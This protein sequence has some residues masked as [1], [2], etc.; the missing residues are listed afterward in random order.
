MPART[1]SRRQIIGFAAAACGTMGLTG[2]GMATSLV[3]TNHVPSA[4]IIAGIS[5]R[6]WTDAIQ[7]AWEGSRPDFRLAFRPR[8]TCGQDADL[9]VMREADVL[10]IDSLSGTGLTVT[11][12]GPTGQKTSPFQNLSEALGP[13]LRTANFNAKALLPGAV[14]AFADFKG[15]LAAFPLMLGEVQCYINQTAL[16]DM[17]LPTALPWTIERMETAVIVARQ[18][19]ATSHSPLVVGCGWSDVNMWSAWVKALGGSVTWRVGG[20]DLR[21]S[22]EATRRLVSFAQVARWDPFPTFRSGTPA[23]DFVQYGFARGA[24]DALFAF[25]TPTYFSGLP[26]SGLNSHVAGSTTLKPLLAGSGTLHTVPF[27]SSYG[28]SPAP[29]VDAVGLVLT[30]SSTRGALAAQFMSWLYEPAQQRLLAGIGF[31]PVV[32]DPDT[33]AYWIRLQG[34][35]ALTT[36]G[37]FDPSRYWD[38]VPLMPAEDLGSWTSAVT[39]TQGPGGVVIH[40]FGL[41][42]TEM[43]RGQDVAHAMATFQKALDIGILPLPEPNCQT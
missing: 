8:S 12:S 15:N 7:H 35:S 30:A 17:G 14:A 42:C 37:W 39:S 40:D 32:S 28:A 6:S 23:G 27:P 2:C 5:S 31:P 19:N 38:V 21:G 43:Y 4:L 25:T 24:A 18:Q 11:V 10:Q 29:A 16:A 9:A 20:V 26:R 36:G 34:D 1:V 13:I 33:Q 3:A 22:I 41:V